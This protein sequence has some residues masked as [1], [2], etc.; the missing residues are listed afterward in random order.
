[1]VLQ[2]EPGQNFPS[3]EDLESLL[4]SRKP[5]SILHYACKNS[6]FTMNLLS[7]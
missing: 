6:D 7:L 1:V 4:T 5:R 2:R 3:L